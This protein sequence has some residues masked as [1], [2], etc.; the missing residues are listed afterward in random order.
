M[1]EDFLDHSFSV[2]VTHLVLEKR[3]I[4][5]FGHRID[6][7]LATQQLPMLGAEGALCPVGFLLVPWHSR[8]STRSPLCSLYGSVS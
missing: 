1:E 6:T 3:E 8:R 5:V 7:W 4:V 2:E